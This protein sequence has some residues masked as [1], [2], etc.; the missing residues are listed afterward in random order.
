MNWLESQAENNRSFREG[1]DDSIVSWFIQ[2]GYCLKRI[3]GVDNQRNDKSLSSTIRILIQNNYISNETVN[4]M[5][6]FIETAPPPDLVWRILNDVYHFWLQKKEL[7]VPLVSSENNKGFILD[8]DDINSFLEGVG[9]PLITD[10]QPESI[11]D[12][13][14]R[15]GRFLMI[16]YG[17]LTNENIHQYSTAVS[18]ERAIKNTK[19]AISLF[20]KK[21][22]LD[23]SFIEAASALV[24]G[25]R[26]VLQQIISVIILNSEKTEKK[27]KEEPS[28]NIEMAYSMNC[29]LNDGVTLPKLISTI[30]VTFQ[31]IPH[32][33][34]SPSN[35]TEIKWNIRKTLE[36][37]ESKPE[38]TYRIDPDSLMKGSIKSI[39]ELCN[40]I[41][42]CYPHKFQ[43]ANSKN[44]VR[45]FL[46]LQ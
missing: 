12:N 5:K 38:W 11:I 41:F 21:G 33:I 40:G 45:I 1:L 16:L 34:L 26:F 32:I 10:S 31:K 17:K 27:K 29:T 14:F 46:G 3:M 22:F 39:E 44:R 30:D 20:E 13:P 28:T 24:S 9:A 2:S 4:Y 6:N 8:I 36:F 35:T 18:T 15:N 25:D 37:L 42:L 43:H 19:I 7:S 23:H